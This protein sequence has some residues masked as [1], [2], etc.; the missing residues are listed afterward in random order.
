MFG[1]AEFAVPILARLAAS[2]WRPALVVTAPDAPAGRGL[3]VTSPPLKV[4]AERLGLPVIQPARLSPLPPEIASPAELFIVAAYGKILPASLLGVPRYGALNVP[5][6]LL[7]RWRG[8]TPIPQ[9]ILAG[10][11]ET[12]V[13]LILMDEEI[14]HGPILNSSKIQR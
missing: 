1:T 12:G 5:P 8:A 9:A 2:P 11:A 6:S 14:D 4:A 3:S 13:T 10:D 7:P